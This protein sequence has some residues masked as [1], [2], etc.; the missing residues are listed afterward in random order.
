MAYITLYIFV[1]FRLKCFRVNRHGLVTIYTTNFRPV[2]HYSVWNSYLTSTSE[3]RREHVGISLDHDKVATHQHTQPLP[4][5]S[6]SLTTGTSY[7]NQWSQPLDEKQ[8]CQ[9][10]NWTTSNIIHP[11][12]QE[13]ATLLLECHR[14]CRIWFKPRTTPDQLSQLIS[15]VIA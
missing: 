3:Y 2:L 12:H 6:S 13:E 8:T 11:L 15:S 7:H 1:L 4:I 14:Y 9:S 10:K 5:I